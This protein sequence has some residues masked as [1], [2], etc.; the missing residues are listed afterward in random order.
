HGAAF[1][2]IN[3]LHAIPNRG[4]GVSPYSP[5]SRLY[6][7]AAY[8][9]IDA[10][11]ELAHSAQAR[12]LLNSDAVRAELAALRAGT[13]VQ[14]ERATLVARPILE[15]LHRTFAAAHPSPNDA[16]R[17]AYERYLAREGDTLTAHATFCALDEYFS[18]HG[19]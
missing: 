11:P 16:R 2:G 6:R 14:Y 9:D 8:L 13:T 5:V 19:I 4:L 17:A 3:P 15:A 12:A 7:S 10:I 1:V 18:A